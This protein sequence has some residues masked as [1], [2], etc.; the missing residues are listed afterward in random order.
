MKL[1]ALA[2]LSVTALLIFAAYVLIEKGERDAMDDQRRLDERAISTIGE[3]IDEA[4]DIDTGDP[5]YIPRGLRGLAGRYADE[6]D[7]TKPADD[8]CD[9]LLQD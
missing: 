2:Y 8:R 1:Q 5:C 7:Q 6:L 4:P 9:D 3:A